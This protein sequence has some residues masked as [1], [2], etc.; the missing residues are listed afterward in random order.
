MAVLNKFEITYKNSAKEDASFIFQYNPA[1]LTINKS[2]NW[3][4][5]SVNGTNLQSKQFASG[6]AKTISISNILFDSTVMGEMNV[7]EEYIEYLE[8]M[9]LVQQFE[10]ELR[11]PLL[12]LS[13]GKGNYFFDC[14]LTTLNYDFTMFNKEG[15]PIRAI[16]SLTFEEIDI[17]N[18]TKKEK[19]KK[20]MKSYTIR[21][22]DTLQKIAQSELGNS[23]QWK[24]IAIA[25]GIDNPMNLTVGQQ[26][27]IPPQ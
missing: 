16:V 10:K 25:N 3:N 2:V 20:A 5:L 8:Q 19:S 7:Y 24:I 12:T 27:Q 11:P 6:N 23:N 17:G 26:L 15:V 1:Q 9:T 14:V 21:S 18:S 22:D 13:W 4:G